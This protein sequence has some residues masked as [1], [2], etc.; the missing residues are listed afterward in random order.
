MALVHVRW[1]KMTSVFSLSVMLCLLLL[2]VGVPI[3]PIPVVVSGVRLSGVSVA[4]V[5]LGITALGP[6]G[7]HACSTAGARAAEL[8]VGVSP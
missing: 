8:T 5:I 4:V 7:A 2:L 1:G 6:A 3:I